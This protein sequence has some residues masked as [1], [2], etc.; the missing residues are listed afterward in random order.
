MERL[1][2]AFLTEELDLTI[3]ESQL[4]WP[5]YNAF[6]NAKEASEKTI[7]TTMRELEEGD[8]TEATVQSAIDTVSKERQNI[9]VLEAQFLSDSMAILGPEKTVKLMSAERSFKHELVRRLQAQK[10]RHGPPGRKQP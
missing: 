1:K 10:D 5:V 6:G 8:K 7:R 2:I 3:E 9:D 4:F